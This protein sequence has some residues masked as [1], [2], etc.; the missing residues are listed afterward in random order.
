MKNEI[1]YNQT[2]TVATLTRDEV[3]NP[4]DLRLMRYSKLDETHEGIPTGKLGNQ[5]GGFPFEL[6]GKVWKGTEYLYLCG[7]WSWEGN[8]ARTIQEDVRSAAS[9]YAAKR[10]KDSKYRRRTRAD[11]ETIRV[12]YMLWCV[13]RKCLGNSDYR[14]LLL[15]LPEDRVVVEVISR[16]PF[17]AAVEGEDGLLRGK[18]IMGKII[19]ICRRCLQQGTEPEIDTDLLNQAGIYLLGERVQF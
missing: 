2:I 13:W 7:K 8:E 15:S 4:Q 11:W 6:N 16:D 3:I 17:W 18:N 5:A 19:T 9:N 1:Q 10:F 12:P 14:A